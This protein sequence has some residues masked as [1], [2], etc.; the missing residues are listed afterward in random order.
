MKKV[1]TINVG[2]R[3]IGSIL[4]RTV[5]VAGVISVALLAPNALGAL[6]SLGLLKKNKRERETISNSYKKMLAKGFMTIDRRGNVQLTKKG[7]QKYREI[8]LGNFEIKTPKS[9]WDGKWRVVVFDVP[10][11]RRRTRDTVRGILVSTGFRKLQN[12]VWVHPYDCQDFV[13][14]MK[15]DMYLNKNILYMTVDEIEN[16]D[17]LRKEFNLV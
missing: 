11:R 6:S 7:L 8:E 13:S 10:E 4:L 3:N 5:G 9:G 1:K 2:R 14:L 12:S 16:N 17:R 15:T